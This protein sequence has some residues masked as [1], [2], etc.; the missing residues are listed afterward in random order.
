MT[1]GLVAGLRVGQAIGMF[2]RLRVRLAVS[3]SRLIGTHLEQLLG[4]L[5]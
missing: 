2:Y 4:N 3:P 5:T 1:A